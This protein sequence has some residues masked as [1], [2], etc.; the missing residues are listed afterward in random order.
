MMGAVPFLW[1]LLL[2][3]CCH[4]NGERTRW[5]IQVEPGH[6]LEASLSSLGVSVVKT[7]PGLDGVH[8]VEDASRSATSR[9]PEEITKR[10]DSLRALPGVVFAE[11][12]V[13]RK[14]HRRGKMN[15]AIQV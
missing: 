14:Q 13:K 3:F 8:V 7:V 12:Q 9:S 11:V 1:L 10:T 2:L 6:D 4:C 15:G 5:A